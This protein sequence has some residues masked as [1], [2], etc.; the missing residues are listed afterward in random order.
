MYPSTK[1]GTTNRLFGTSIAPKSSSDLEK[2]YL[3]IWSKHDT[4]LV[5]SAI[6]GVSPSAEAWYE[7]VSGLFSYAFV[8]SGG[9]SAV[10]DH[11]V[12]HLLCR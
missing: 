12:L 10:D 3:R 1:D 5:V 9:A 2:F 7:I 6:Y 8:M 11:L 4:I